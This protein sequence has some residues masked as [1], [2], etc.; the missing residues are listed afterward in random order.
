MEL[1]SFRGARQFLFH[2]SPSLMMWVG[3]PGQLPL[4]V[5]VST[6][7]LL[8]FSLHVLFRYCNCSTAIILFQVHELFLAAFVCCS[9]ADMSLRELL[10]NQLPKDRFFS[11]LI[12]PGNPISLRYQWCEPPL[13]RVIMI[14][15]HVRKDKSA[16]S[17]V[18]ALKCKYFQKCFS[19]S[20]LRCFPASLGGCFFKRFPAVFRCFPGL[21]LA[22]DGIF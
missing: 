16:Q 14:A 13:P 4:P 18:E 8:I 22:C 1:W 5:A 17:R 15:Q 10:V 7:Q 11:L 3:L 6:N 19:N 20:P 2:D 21:F 9:V 12:R